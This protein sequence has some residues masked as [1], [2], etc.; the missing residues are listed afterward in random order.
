VSHWFIECLII[1]RLNL[2]W[3][4]HDRSDQQH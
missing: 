1:D 4:R 2:H 3:K